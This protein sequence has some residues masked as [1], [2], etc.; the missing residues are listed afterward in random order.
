MGKSEEKGFGGVLAQIELSTLVF[1][2]PSILPG[3]MCSGD[4]DENW[5]FRF[6]VYAGKGAPA[7]FIML[8]CSSGQKSTPRRVLKASPAQS[9]SC[10]IILSISS[11]PNMH[12][13]LTYTFVGALALGVAAAPTRRNVNTCL[14][15]FGTQEV[16]L[17]S[18]IYRKS[19]HQ[20]VVSS[21]RD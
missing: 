19:F 12:S 2:V 1:A 14:P 5:T 3:C 10:F 9:L 13:A 8:C 4:S 20:A 17:T 11:N 18:S 15:Y 7:K 6:P 16:S 21:H